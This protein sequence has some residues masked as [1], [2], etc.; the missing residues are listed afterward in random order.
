M[1]FRKIIELFH[2]IHSI[3][4][5]AELGFEPRIQRFLEDQLLGVEAAAKQDSG[6]LKR[7]DAD[8]RSVRECP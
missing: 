7:L 8:E 3:D 2:R 6:L 4:L 5:K 1:P